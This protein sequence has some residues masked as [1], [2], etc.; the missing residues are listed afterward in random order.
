MATTESRPAFRLPWS[1]DRAPSHDESQDEAELVTAAAAL[2]E[3]TSDDGFTASAPE[4]ASDVAEAEAAATDTQATATDDATDHDPAAVP[5]VATPTTLGTG[6]DGASAP[7]RRP[8][9]FLLDMTHAMQVAAEQARAATLD[10]FRVEGAAYVEQIQGRSAADTDALRRRADDDVASIKDWS[11]AEIARI[12][13]ETETRI[14]G[15]RGQLDEQLARH[16]ALVERDIARIEAQIASFEA[17]MAAFFDELLAETDLS[18]LAARAQQ[19]PEA[20]DFDQLDESAFNALMNEPAVGV[21]VAPA[22]AE[23]EPVAAQA[24]LGDAGIADTTNTADMAADITAEA[25]T[26]NRRTDGLDHLAGR[27]RAAGPRS[28]HG[29]DP[30]GRG[31]R[32][33]SRGSGGLGRSGRHGRRGDPGGFG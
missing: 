30:G 29:R 21:P 11:K 13:E 12:R 16:A 17:E 26:G 23:P 5:V 3:P 25:Q 27:Q 1:A 6:A 24:A 22:A 14:S 2:D 19:M 28:R 32:R 8:T 31:G 10:Q 15:R 18:V 20:P 9:K 7:S 4:D 33:G